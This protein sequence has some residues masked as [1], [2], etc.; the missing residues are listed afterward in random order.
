MQEFGKVVQFF[1]NKRFSSGRRINHLTG[2]RRCNAGSVKFSHGHVRVAKRTEDGSHRPQRKR[3]TLQTVHP[4]PKSLTIPQRFFGS[5]ISLRVCIKKLEQV[6]RRR[7][8]IFN[9]ARSLSLQNRDDLDKDLLL[10]EK[11]HLLMKAL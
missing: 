2:R 7:N 10:W 3:T 1:Q 6:V 5:C 8:D 4:F 9:F 11:P